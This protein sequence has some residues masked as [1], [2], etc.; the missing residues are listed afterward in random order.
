MTEK[1]PWMKQPGEVCDSRGVPIYPGDLI[2]S[3][4]FTGARNKRYYLYHTAVYQDGGMW[5]VPTS[6][7]EPAK[8]ASGG[9]CLLGQDLMAEAEVISGYGPG[10]CVDYTD[11]PRRKAPTT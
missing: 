7:L 4:H 6:H 2:R 5:L 1:K 8:V 9:K 10:E 11:R 3:Y